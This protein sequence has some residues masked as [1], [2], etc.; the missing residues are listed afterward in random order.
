MAFKKNLGSAQLLTK[1]DKCDFVSCFD[2]REV[3]RSPVKWNWN[4]LSFLQF[5]FSFE[6]C[7]LE[8]HFQFRWK[9]AKFA[10]HKLFWSGNVFVI[11]ILDSF[12]TKNPSQF[13]KVKHCH[14]LPFC[15]NE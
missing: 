1:I 9:N 12:Q 14:H 2:I 15:A 7:E 8:G 5:I 13:K 6:Q 10:V 4:R 11:Q 3:P